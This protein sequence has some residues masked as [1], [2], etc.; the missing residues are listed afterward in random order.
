VVASGRPGLVERDDGARAAVGRQAVDEA[1]RRRAG[2][3]RRARRR[4]R[5]VGS[6]VHAL[7]HEPVLPG[8]GR[9]RER[10]AAVVDEQLLRLAP[11]DRGRA[12]GQREDRFA[13]GRRLRHQRHSAA[14]DGLAWVLRAP[15]RR[16]GRRAGVAR[17]ERER[18]R[19]REGA[20]LQHHRD[21]LAGLGSGRHG[22]QRRAR[23]VART[24]QAL[25][26][27]G[28]RAGPGVVAFRRDV[29][30]G[31]RRGRRAGRMR[32]VGAGGCRLRRGGRIGAAAACGER[33]GERGRDDG[34]PGP[35]PRGFV[36]GHG[37]S[38]MSWTAG[39]P[40]R[41]RA[42]SIAARHVAPGSS[43]RMAAASR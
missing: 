33:Q 4:A 2:G 17:R 15:D 39:A 24:R 19:E 6:H 36:S 32:G 14:D 13:R 20:V 11:V 16:V 5:T 42:R 8:V 25:H 12:R 21:A 23:E 41:R 35:P 22:G 34:A 28:R 37:S 40:R 27:L 10:G 26:R 31:R 9:A 43:R 3:E 38:L 18:G 30:R 1:L 7:V 29:D